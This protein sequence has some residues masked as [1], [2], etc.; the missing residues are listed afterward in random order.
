MDTQTALNQ[1]QTFLQP[2]TV[3]TTQPQPHRLDVC[4]EREHFKQAI[5]AV[6]QAHWGYLAAITGLD[7][8]PGENQEG[9]VEGLYQFCE[10]AA[11]LTIR[12][13]IP[14]SDPYL[15]SIC[16]LIPAAT[17]YEREFIEMFGVF[18]EGTPSTERLLLA[19][20]WPL[21][22]YPLRKSFTGLDALEKG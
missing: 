2:W 11:V 20:E 10:G 8:P 18:L 14:Y 6:K 5:K 17:L 4:V 22:V 1:A 16:D 21:G 3:S 9:A 7:V 19:D 15:P 13:T 12:V